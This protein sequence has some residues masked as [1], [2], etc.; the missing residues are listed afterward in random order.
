MKRPDQYPEDSLVL[1]QYIG[2]L[3]SDNYAIRK[4]YDGSSQFIDT[5]FEPSDE[6]HLIFA[7]NVDCKPVTIFEGTQYQLLESYEKQKQQ[8]TKLENFI[9]GN[10]NDAFDNE[11][12]LQEF[13]EDGNILL[14]KDK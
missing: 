10:L 12:V 8:I 7:Q 5:G 1:W 6:A 11:F 13:I 2:W 4:G 9:Q 3:E 14:N